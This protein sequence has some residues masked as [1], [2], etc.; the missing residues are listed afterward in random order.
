MGAALTSPSAYSISGS[1]S[2][3][4][5]LT[6]LI[7][8]Y[9]HLVAQLSVDLKPVIYSNWK[10]PVAEFELGVA[11]VT[12]PQLQGVAARAGLS[13]DFRRHQLV[14][15]LEWQKRLRGSLVTLPDVLK[16]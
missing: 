5:V 16:V 3:T 15:P 1:S 10:L 14:T 11:D 4:I 7:G 9:I 2:Q 13:V 8:D 12:L 6:S